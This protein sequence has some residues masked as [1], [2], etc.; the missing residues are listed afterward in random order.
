MKGI[1]GWKQKRAMMMKIWM[2]FFRKWLA[3]ERTTFVTLALAECPAP[4]L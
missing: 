4:R 2:G 1:S 3:A